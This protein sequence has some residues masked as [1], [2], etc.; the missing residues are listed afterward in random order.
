M[1]QSQLD[2]SSFYSGKESRRRKRLAVSKEKLYISVQ[3]RLRTLRRAPRRKLERQR[4][5]GLWILSNDADFH[6]AEQE[7]SYPRA[8][9]LGLP[10]ELRQQIL[11]SSYDKQP[12]TRNILEH[13]GEGPHPRKHR[14]GSSRTPNHKHSATSSFRDRALELSQ[15][16]KVFEADMRWVRKQWQRR[17][18]GAAHQKIAVVTLG[19]SNV[20]MQPSLLHNRQRQTCEVILGDDRSV[21]RRRGGKCW[22]CTE[23]HARGQPW[24]SEATADPQR[25]MQE[26]RKRGGWRSIVPV[27]GA[28]SAT[29][30]VFG[31]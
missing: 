12:L 8:S 26:T 10:A 7:R 28:V 13:L 2:S 29:K 11:N 18:G 30:V 5:P 31:D 25:W 17:F 24:C 9:L 19:L 14:K 27:R 6:F 23:R 21:N 22:Y 3:P 1:P 16:C 15:V 20:D 4:A